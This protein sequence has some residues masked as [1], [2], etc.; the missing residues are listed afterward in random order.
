MCAGA[1]ESG[2]HHP[3][4]TACSAEPWEAVGLR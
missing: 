3:R 2:V 4:V 1:G